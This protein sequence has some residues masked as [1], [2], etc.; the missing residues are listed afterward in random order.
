MS[1]LQVQNEL[2]ISLVVYYIR[3][4][5]VEPKFVKIF[6]EFSKFFKNIF[7]ASIFFN[8][9]IAVLNVLSWQQRQTQQFAIDHFCAIVICD[10]LE[11]MKYA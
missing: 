8:Q 9:H 2:N 4:Y 3:T 5:Q 6:E 1:L 10:Q 11:Y 7:G